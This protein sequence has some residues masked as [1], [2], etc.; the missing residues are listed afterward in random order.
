MEPPFTMKLPILQRA[1]PAMALMLMA[2]ASTLYSQDPADDPNDGKLIDCGADKAVLFGKTM[3]PDGR[4]AAGWT[5]RRLDPKAERVDWSKWDAH[6]NANSFLDDYDYFDPQVTG[7]GEAPLV[8]AA[9]SALAPA[10]QPAA[11]YEL[12]DCIIDLKKKTLLPLPSSWPYWPN[13]NHGDFKVIWHRAADG[14][15]YATVFNEARWFTH[16][17]WLVE[18][19]GDAMKSTPLV[20]PLSEAVARV[21]KTKRPLSCD[22]Y[23]V[24]F[25]PDPDIKGSVSFTKT[26]V[27]LLFGAEIPKLDYEQLGGSVIID[28]R[29]GKIVQTKCT[30]PR[31]DPFLDNRE[32]AKADKELNAV[33]AA[34]L[35]KLPAAEQEKLRQQQRY[36]LANRDYAGPSDAGS[37]LSASV[38]VFKTE[39][40]SA[41]PDISEVEEDAFNAKRDAS[42]I[43]STKART[44]ELKEQLAAQ[45]AR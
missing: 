44:A 18:A 30:T 8:D 41:V 1:A 10:G 29:S 19:K 27:A 34:L 2:L 35:A 23:A 24:S 13:K 37:H 12:L 36:W 3:S 14:T 6:A 7:S 42:L 38:I 39:H 43:R 5:L 20:D 28:L 31:D 33:Y 9:K 32:L 22:A 4:Y 45:K 26:T 15:E 21:L 16:D 40:L 25:F 11:P 17:V